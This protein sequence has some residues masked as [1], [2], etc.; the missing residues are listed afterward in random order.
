MSPDTAPSA[1]TPAS[2]TP[3]RAR[4]AA[5]GHTVVG[6]GASAGGMQALTRFFAQM[7]A[8]S[9]MSFVVVLHLS[10]A[11]ESHAAG[12]LQ[13]ATSLP[14]SEVT[15]AVLL[16]PDHV[17][18]IPPARA[19]GMEDG[20]LYL[21]DE[22]R[23]AGRN[24]AIDTFFRAL[25]QAHRHKA[26]GVVLSGTGTD[27]S[28]GLTRIKEL[29]GLT[30]AQAPEDAEHGGMPLAAIG[31]GMVD[32]VLPVDQM[33]DKLLQLAA[34]A[35]A[36]RLPADA[37][38]GLGARPA[39]TRDDEQRDEAALAEIMGVLRQRTGHDFRH[40]KRPTVLRRLERRMQV[41]ALPSLSAYRDHLLSHVE[42]TP[43]LLQD[44]L[45]SV[46]NFFRDRT[47]F[48]ALEQD[49]LP[50]LQSPSDGESGLRAWVVGCAS[51]EEAYS[52]AMLL[53][54]ERARRAQAAPFQVFATDIDQRALAVARTGVYPGSI[55]ADVPA[56]R[57]SQFFVPEH[58][59]FRV[60]KS[61]RERVL[62]AQHNVLR[63]PPFSRVDI[64]VCRNL[65]IYL[66]RSAQAAVLET[67]RFAL[68]PGGVLFLGSSE[69]AD[70]AGDLFVAVDK[71][72]RIFR[73]APAATPAPAPL[74]GARAAPAP[75]PGPPPPPAATPV[76][77]RMAVAD[78]HQRATLAGAPPSV[79]IDAQ[80]K[81]LHLSSG[82]PRFLQVQD[83]APS[84]NLIDNVDPRL[85]L[86]LRTVLFRATPVAPDEEPREASV[87]CQLGDER[88]RIVVQPAH[89]A[90]EGLNLLRVVF[91]P[92]EP[93]PDA[94]PR[95]LSADDAAMHHEAE[96]AV[97]AL[98]DENRRL[99][100]HLQDVVEHAEASTEELMSSNEEL[101]AVNEELR[102]ATEELET[103]REELQSTNEELITVNS[104]LALKVDETARV[105]DDL[106]NLIN[107]N[108]I[109]TV[110]VDH[111]LRIKRYTPRAR[112]LF[113]LIPSD[114]G[115]PLLD[116]THRLDYAQLVQDAQ[117]AFEALH[118][119]EREVRG[120]EGGHFV[121]RMLPYRTVDDKIEGAILSFIDV[122][123]L[124]ESQQEAIAGAER[125][126]LAA[127]STRDFAIVTTDEQGIVT[128][129]N[130]GAARLFGYT[131]GDIV[132]QPVALIFT[133][134]DRAAGVPE[135]ELALAREQGRSEDDRWYR[136]KEGGVFY[137]SGVTTQLAD[138]RGF[139]MITRDLTGSRQAALAR[140]RLLSNEREGR[141]QAEATME[142]KEL[143][144]AVMSH[145]LKHPLN[146][147]HM[148]A[149]V[150]ARLPEIRQV[151]AA[152]RAAQVIQQTVAGQARIVDDLLDLSRA[153]T[154]KL[155]LEPA[156][157]DWNAVVRRIVDAL[158]P[159]AQDKGV[160]LQ[161]E[162]P[163][164]APVSLFDPVRADQ[165]VWNLVTNAIKFTPAGGSVRVVLRDDGESAHLSVTDSGR[166]I[167]PAYIDSVFDM[168]SQDS[169]SGQ[170]QNDG[171]G[172]GLALVR[173]L[174]Q[175]HGG[176]A[177]VRSEGVGRGAEFSIWVPLH[178]G[179]APAPAPAV[180]QSALQGKRL[181]VV[182]DSQ[183]SVES[184]G[185]LL[186]LSGAAV[187]TA[188]SGAD[189]LARMDD[190]SFD[191]LISDISMPGMNGYEL[192][193]AV[194]AR[195]DGQQL[196]ALACSGYS[197]SQDDARAREAGFDAL[198]AKPASL[199]EV[200]RVIGAA[201][202]RGAR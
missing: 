127:E 200:E 92:L 6:L 191:V 162:T 110:F 101:Q 107:A 58:D 39:P 196:L 75:A 129:W 189:A 54:D 8:T 163:R 21:S 55:V 1:D 143:F 89:D 103:S 198:I 153:R 100:R 20:R 116:I 85:R 161:L 168:F 120:I 150:L 52:L 95:A 51:G 96:Q 62:F 15:E 9:G 175:A 46:T 125:L 114:V 12:I 98:D 34:N 86:E 33:P 171:L 27:G 47:A 11:H 167:A 128:A 201:R 170:P 80:H 73:L 155:R 37:A 17:Y 113:N 97:R 50:T 104:Q 169:G 141:R 7:P 142:A 69:S 63:D 70:V 25:A 29:G 134:E 117:A 115:R 65:L 194:R 28:V 82:M 61:L 42:E 31:T 146:L 44:M 147:I 18:V 64:I 66:D 137:C 174:V 149:E 67:F 183:D 187:T 173:E 109:A 199:E 19:L 182:D 202:G 165:V 158:R 166:G 14:V 156:A 195:A 13:R 172:I 185:M 38:S 71:R 177:Q 176:R 60:V 59:H 41:T 99:Q 124:R 90:H 152:A 118:V 130:Q 87:E 179:P 160:R 3:A 138:G 40:Y 26:A 121:A 122:T 123:A 48:Q 126:R 56:A 184:F 49:V 79:L 23:V 2:N 190:Q 102:S 186:G 74:R 131:E 32:F 192:I 43:A 108:D 157:V 180:V 68:R 181:L 24:V 94:P 35:Q 36:M 88:L 132:G 112:Q 178:K 83:G 91:E 22:G 16:E 154:G 151:P 53:H 57:L 140:E 106:Q 148:N 105:N 30:F 159:G 145:E 81:I 188:T 84:H 139:A 45:I 76:A 193:Q 72:H 77:R 135:Q 197:R 119:V 93:R 144:L 4:R 164:P 5:L 133:E 78:L 136:R 10:P 111:A